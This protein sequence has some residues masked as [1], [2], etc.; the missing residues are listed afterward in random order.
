MSREITDGTLPTQIQDFLTV[1]ETVLA[2]TQHV[3]TADFTL[4]IYKLL[5][6]AH[7]ASEYP[8]E[9]FYENELL[10]WL[11]SCLETFKIDGTGPVY[12]FDTLFFEPKS[13]K[14]SAS[15]T[16]IT[17]LEKDFLA[18]STTPIFISNADG[19]TNLTLMVKLSGFFS[20]FR[21]ELE[22]TKLRTPILYPALQEAL[23][24][25]RCYISQ[26]YPE[27][28]LN[29][30]DVNYTYVN[31]AYPTAARVMSLS[32]YRETTIPYESPLFSTEFL[33]PTYQFLLRACSEVTEQPFYLQSQLMRIKTCMEPA[34]NATGYVKTVYA[35]IEACKET[36]RTDRWGT[37]LSNIL[38]TLK[39]RIALYISTIHPSLTLDKLRNTSPLSAYKSAK[40]CFDT[41]S[42]S[43][44]EDFSTITSWFFNDYDEWYS[45]DREIPF[46]PLRCWI[47]TW[48][49]KW[50]PLFNNLHAT[51][52][53]IRLFSSTVS[54]AEDQCRKKHQSS[55]N[56]IFFSDSFNRV[57]DRFSNNKHH[58]LYYIEY[59]RGGGERYI[60]VFFKFLHWIIAKHLEEQNATL[61]PFEQTTERSSICAHI[62]RLSLEDFLKPTA[63]SGAI[64]SDEFVR[65]AYATII[66]AQKNRAY[67]AQVTY[68]NDLCMELK[69]Q[70]E[71]LKHED[72][73]LPKNLRIFFDFL[74]ECLRSF[75]ASMQYDTPEFKDASELH[76]AFSTI[77]NNAERLIQIYYP[78]LETR[79]K[80][81][82]HRK[83]LELVDVAE[84][85]M[86]GIALPATNPSELRYESFS[87]STI[88]NTNRVFSAAL[89]E[90]I[91]RALASTQTDTTTLYPQT[92]LCPIKRELQNNCTRSNFDEIC[93]FIAENLTRLKEKEP[94]LHRRIAKNFS[95]IQTDITEYFKLAYPETHQTLL[96]SWEKVTFVLFHKE[97]SFKQRFCCCFFKADL[98][99]D[100]EENQHEMSMH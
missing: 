87:Q 28:S 5:A 17:Q 89:V 63:D 78:E 12:L 72:P 7:A 68:L 83:T 46:S 75:A 62:D 66:T 34:L 76:A 36:L 64:F 74:A 59:P 42:A 30:V 70:L 1:D 95:A 39:E 15:W 33:T 52:T 45:D 51:P 100:A 90:K 98:D 16:Y 14:L 57:T 81:D 26:R 99:S 23:E 44:A 67:T 29:N 6:D 86:A 53:D 88:P 65:Q 94:V 58:L 22:T 4:E 18:K 79:Y 13:D 61:Y 40:Y 60:L 41:H 96:D 93:K 71:S 54:T 25:C 27:F 9:L 77:K 97:I 56:K 69:R 47:K 84:E 48:W 19:E 24:R 80:I 85:Q 11:K 2:K 10:L 38:N 73:E 92:L 43:T 49:E 91:L 3:F 21:E 35:E 31:Y 50:L 55:S 32:A 8:I 37:E 20:A 82:R